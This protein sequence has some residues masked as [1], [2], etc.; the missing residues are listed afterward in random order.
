MTAQVEHFIGQH[1]DTRLIVID[2]LQHIRGVATD[3][4]L[5]VN[6]YTDMNILR[7]ITS[8]YDVAV[9]LVT[10]TRKM[11]DAD[12]LNRISGSTGLIG[13]S[14]GA[15]IL[16]KE[17][18]TENRGRLT[19]SNRDTENHVFEIEFDAAVCRWNILEEVN[20]QHKDD[21]LYAFLVAFMADKGRWRGTATELAELALEYGL[22]F[23]SATLSKRIRASK[24]TLYN[25]YCIDVRF[26]TRQNTK[27]IDLIKTEMR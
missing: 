1:P 19:V 4:N 7:E 11:D 18:R 10:H 5:Y 16:E 24:Q 23:T 9:V 25:K 3:K 20:P 27:H 21:P 6:D 2:T 12:P 8:R 14:D 17:T 22:G 26:S 13:A 15:F